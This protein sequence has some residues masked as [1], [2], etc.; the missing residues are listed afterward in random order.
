MS[1]RSERA[2]W[3]KRIHHEQKI[4]LTLSV[5]KNAP[6]FASLRF[7]PRSAL[8][9]VEGADIINQICNVQRVNLSDVERLLGEPDKIFGVTYLSFAFQKMSLPADHGLERPTMRIRVY[10]ANGGQISKKKG[11][12]EDNLAEKPQCISL[13]M[14]LNDDYVFWGSTWHLQTALEDLVGAFAIFELVKKTG[15]CVAWCHVGLNKDSEA[16]NTMSKSLEF[17]AAPVDLSLKKMEK[18]EYFLNGVMSLTKL[19]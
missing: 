1:E 3:E 7:A 4:Q 2:L 18:S 10:A 12:E 19:E 16:C 15:E 13:P 11:A 5:H 8:D 9:M 14:V 6:H 17:S